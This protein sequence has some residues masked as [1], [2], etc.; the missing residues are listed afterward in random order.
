MTQETELSHPMVHYLLT[1][2]KLKENKGF[3]RATDIAKDLGLTKG[4]VSSML[5]SLK[6]KNFIKDEIDCKFVIL[7]KEGH[8]EVHRILSARTLLYYFLRDFVGVDDATAKNDSCQMEHL[9]SAETGEKFFK[10]MKNL[11]CSGDQN[12]KLNFKTA[13]D[14]CS[15][16]TIDD[17]L[18]QQRGDAHL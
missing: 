11:A 10:F 6:K 18:H 4:T 9:M 2:H 8:D 1:I 7:T 17:F 15:Y 5:A 13:L 16:T 3:A 14:L 12:K